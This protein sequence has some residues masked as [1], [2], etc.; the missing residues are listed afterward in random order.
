[1]LDSSTHYLRTQ[2]S[3]TS[4]ANRNREQERKGESKRCVILARYTTTST[5]L[6]A[7]RRHLARLLTHDL[8]TQV[9]ITLYSTLLPRKFTLPARNDSPSQALSRVASPLNRLTV[10]GESHRAR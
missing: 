8:R 2:V 5:Y 3:I 10:V 7:Y 9:S 1:M 6:L 4:T